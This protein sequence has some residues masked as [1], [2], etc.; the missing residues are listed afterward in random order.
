MGKRGDVN[1]KKKLKLL[2]VYKNYLVVTGIE[3]F[4]SILDYNIL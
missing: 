3:S 4:I 1:L 2:N